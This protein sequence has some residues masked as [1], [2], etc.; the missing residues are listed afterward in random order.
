[1]KIEVLPHL[2][3]RHPDDSFTDVTPV[4]ELLTVETDHVVL[5]PINNDHLKCTLRIEI[6]PDSG[7]LLCAPA[8]DVE[9]S[10]AYSEKGFVFYGAT[11]TCF[12]EFSNE[13][14][15]VQGGRVN[16]SQKMVRADAGPETEFILT[17]MW[18]E[19]TAV[20][21]APRV[22]TIAHINPDSRV[23]AAMLAP[24][25]HALQR[26]VAAEEEERKKNVNIEEVWTKKQINDEFFSWFNNLTEVALIVMEHSDRVEFCNAMPKGAITDKAGLKQVKKLYPGKNV[27]YH[28]DFVTMKINAP[29]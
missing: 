20:T 29:F 10:E 2:A 5:C 28:R 27:M 8:G 6:D 15:R 12:A 16:F 13:N 19:Y 17:P 14:R 25:L 11:L 22:G 9:I 18:N 1:M 26:K 3:I 24:A 21:E 7:A 4:G 23:T